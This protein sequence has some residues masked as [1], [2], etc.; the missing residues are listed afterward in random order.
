MIA[1]G[2]SH[3]ETLAGRLTDGAEKAFMTTLLA[4]NTTIS[5]SLAFVGED[6]VWLFAGPTGQVG[7][8]LLLLP[9][10]TAAA[11]ADGT[12][13]KFYDELAATLQETLKRTRET[14]FPETEC[15]SI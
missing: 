13:D 12:M 9:E 15:E 4:E 3:L 14:L 10:L 1:D 11:R 6:V 7:I 8:P 2:R 5:A